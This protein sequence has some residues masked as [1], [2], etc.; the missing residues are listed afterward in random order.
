RYAAPDTELERLVC[1]PYDVISPDEQRALLAA[2]AQNAVRLELPTD[3]PGHAGTRYAAAASDLSAWRSAGVL[4]GDPNA[5]YYLSETEYSFA[6]GTLHRRDVLAAL[7]VEPWSARVALPHEHTMAAPKADR[8]ELLR[9]TH[10]NAS[11]IWLL[12]RERPAALEQAWD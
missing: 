8:L 7:P 5:A 2:S 12:A 1:P 11:P 6:N 3:E 9:A 10:L 4:Q